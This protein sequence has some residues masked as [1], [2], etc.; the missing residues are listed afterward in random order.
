MKKKLL[1]VFATFLLSQHATLSQAFERFTVK[2]I[3]V[4]GLQRI[5]IGTVFNYLPIHPGE[6]LAEEKSAELL[7]ALFE[8]GFFQD[9]QLSR[10]GEILV[11]QVVERPTIGKI[12]VSGNKD[13]STE[14]LMSTLKTAGLAEGYVFDR[15]VLEQVR[16]ELERL[17]FA[18]GKYGV[19]LE[20]TV[21][22][23]EH[24][25]VQ[26][27]IDITEG[28]AA[29]IKEISIVGNQRFSTADLLKFFKLSSTNIVS[30]VSKAD[31]Y[32]KQKLSAD[33]E[34]LRTF[35]LDRGY[36]QFQI[37][38]TQVSITPDKQDIFITINIEE[39]LQFSLEKYA[40]GG[41]YIL[42]EATLMDLI[43]LKPGIFSRAKVAEAVKVLQ[44]RLG[45]AGYAFAK[46]NPVPEL[47]EVEQKVSLTFYIEP[48]NKMNVRRILFEGNA[49]TKDEVIRRELIQL[50]SAPMNTKS[51]EESRTRLNRTGYFTE[52]KS[53]VRPVPGTTD[54]VD[55][56]YVVEEASAGQLGGGIGYSDADGLL[57][58]ANVSNRN[59]L[60][61]GNSLDFNFN[62]SK[63]YTTYSLAYN[64]PYYTEEGV[65]RGFNLFYSETDLGKATQVANY[66]TDAY[67]ANVTYGVPLSPVDRFT[68]GYGFQSTQLALMNS[69]APLEIL[70]FLDQNKNR[71]DELSIAFGWTHS[72]LD[73]FVFPESG[74]S[75]S[76]GVRASVP[77]ST[78]EY[79]IFNYHLQWYRRL[80]KGFIYNANA[81]VG[82]G[83][84]Y[85]HTS[86]LPFY[87]NFFAG[88]VRTVRA[89]E[90]NSLGP[91]DSQGNPFGGNLLFCHSSSLILPNDFFPETKS[92]RLAWFVDVGQVYD[93][94]E[95]Q[96]LI[97]PLLSRNPNG[98]RF[99]TGLSLTWISPMGPLLFSLATPLNKHEGDKV[100]YFA[101][102][103]GSV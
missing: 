3:Q 82:Y 8:T 68:Y 61:T 80:G 59:F 24:N 63:A 49:K 34:A 97:D 23:K 14:N 89:F 38:S 70:D 31:Q 27:A 93:T 57:F 94:V 88:G 18:H 72:D 11:I 69:F 46:V 101:F 10:K 79:Y 62:R 54:Q 1:A 87:K 12:T 4:E 42:P 83:D 37:L 103:F 53:E 55:I 85:R 81:T 45:E 102:T 51:I 50:E 15:S 32:D 25:R 35:Y 44:D 90:E 21:Q 16:N 76:F 74:L 17:Y 58:N 64:N 5:S 78:L 26:I 28:K 66:T 65:S 100:Q 13:I 73:R 6:E 86:Q 41:N 95:K 60:G 7:R 19:K 47:Q 39:G 22:K 77:G 99:S 40:L 9:I 36:L 20:T 33:L 48:G 67:G 43:P 30:W 75:Q 71:S 2:E 96:S 56:V 29:H 98:V 52:V 84:G 91:R 92:I